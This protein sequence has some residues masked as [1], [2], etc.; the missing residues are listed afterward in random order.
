MTGGP[1]RF[2]REAF[3]R[4]GYERELAAITEVLR[5]PDASAPVTAS[6][7]YELER[8]VGKYPDDARRLVAELPPPTAASP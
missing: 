5:G 1:G 8:L 4:D 3:D 7:L 2:S 6:E